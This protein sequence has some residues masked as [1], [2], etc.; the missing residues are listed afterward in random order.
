MASDFKPDFD[1]E[2]LFSQN[3]VREEF[4]RFQLPGLN[5]P[6]N[7]TPHERYTRTEYHSEPGMEPTVTVYPAQ[8]EGLDLFRTALNDADVDNGYVSYVL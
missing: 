6:I 3:A 8:G 4:S 1:V 5:L 2:K 7:W